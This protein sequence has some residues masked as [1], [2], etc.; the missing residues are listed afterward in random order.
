MITCIKSHIQSKH[1]G[2]INCCSLMRFKLG[3]GRHNRRQLLLGGLC[4]LIGLIHLS[5]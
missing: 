1:L 3:F 2:S 5:L 4:F